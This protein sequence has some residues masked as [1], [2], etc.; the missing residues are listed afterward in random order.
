MSAEPKPD[1][2]E[3]PDFA[4]TLRK[5]RLRSE[6][7]VRRALNRAKAHYPVRL[8]DELNDASRALDSALNVEHRGAFR[9]ALMRSLSPGMV[10]DWPANAALEG[11]SGK[12]AVWLSNAHQGRCRVGCE[13]P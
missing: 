6:Q 8:A 2:S 11:W 12:Q 5:Q 7:V 3:F 1:F 9:S 4:D 10:S 13:L